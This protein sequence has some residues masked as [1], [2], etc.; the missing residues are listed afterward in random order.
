MKTAF[1]FAANIV[2]L[3]LASAPLMQSQA[4]NGNGHANNE[5]LVEVKT[6]KAAYAVGEPIYFTATL[7]NVGDSVVYIAKTF[8]E[9]GGGT[10][11][12]DLTVEQLSG[13]RS[14]IGCLGVGDRGIFPES[15]TPQQILQEDFLRL[16]PGGIVGYRSEYRGCTIAHP[17]RYQVK[18]TYCACDLNTRLVKSSVE[19]A[20]KVVAG[21]ISPH[22]GCS[23][24]VIHTEWDYRRISVATP[25]PWKTVSRNRG[26]TNAGYRSL[27]VMDH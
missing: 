3:A 24:F 19:E 21:E 5:L 25:V 8:F 1:V 23:A 17:G 9:Q 13:K 7:T 11:G 2:A 15:R 20:A 26:F 27:E 12:F 10:A 6:D 14:G 16:P 4:T 22:L 18:A